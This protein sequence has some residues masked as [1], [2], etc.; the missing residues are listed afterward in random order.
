MRAARATP[1]A[2]WPRRSSAAHTTAAP[3]TPWSPRAAT[4]AANEG[5]NAHTSEAA[6]KTTVPTAK[7]AGGRRR[8]AKAIGTA[9]RARPRLKEVSAHASVPTSTSYRPR[10]SGNAS[11]TTDES[12]S[13]TPTERPSSATRVRASIAAT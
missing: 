2:A 12:A 11:V 1:P 13:T 10:I 3:A 5:A 6:E 4:S 8:A 7:I 9:A